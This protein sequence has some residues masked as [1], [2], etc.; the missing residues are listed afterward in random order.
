VGRWDR[1]TIFE[2]LR[3]HAGTEVATSKATKLEVITS[4]AARPSGVVGASG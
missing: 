4:E 3:R 2:I 1:R